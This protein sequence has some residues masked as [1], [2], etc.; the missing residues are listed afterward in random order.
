[1][2][3][4][5][6]IL[7]GCVVE[8]EGCLMIEPKLF[9]DDSPGGHRLL[10]RAE[11]LANVGIWHW[12]VESA[13][14]QW[15]KNVFRLYGVEASETTVSREVPLAGTHPEDRPRLEDY[16]A[17]ILRGER[18]EPLEYRFV[19]PGGGI[20]T[21]RSTVATVEVA[22]TG[23]RSIAGIVQDITEVSWAQSSASL[24]AAVARGLGEWQSFERGATGLLERVCDALEFDLGALWLPVGDVLV[25]RAVWQGSS[26][27]TPR[28]ESSLRSTSLRQ[29]DEA[30]ASAAWRSRRVEHSVSLSRTTGLTDRLHPVTVRAGLAIPAV[31]GDVVM[32]VLGFASMRPVQLTEQVVSGLDDIVHA[33]GDFL[34]LRLG[35]RAPLPITPRELE[36]LDL[37]AHGCSVSQIAARLGVSSN[38]VKTY[39]DRAYR[40]LG[41]SDRAE[42]VAVLMRRGLII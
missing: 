30:L 26:L 32:A 11:S 2:F 10:E 9:R 13:V 25:A 38:T 3:R 17:A 15:S 5:G 7:S 21:M 14:L 1:M 20:R 8:H 39:F 40:K 12:S 19:R 41:V 24:C 23:A 27:P 18:R 29:D 34:T 22:E 37:A 4:A 31:A 35:E 16:S 28:L 42:A 6:P 36:I 33:L